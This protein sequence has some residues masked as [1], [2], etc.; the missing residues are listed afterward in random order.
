MGWYEP[1]DNAQ[2]DFNDSNNSAGRAY[3]KLTTSLLAHYAELSV[4]IA[5]NTF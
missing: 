4:L 2:A 3:A 5:V 1:A